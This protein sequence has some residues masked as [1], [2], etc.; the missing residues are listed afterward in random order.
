MLQSETH[1][2]H[3]QQILAANTQCNTMEIGQNSCREFPVLMKLIDLQEM[4][5]MK[6]K[7]ARKEVQSQSKTS[8]TNIFYELDNR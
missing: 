2:I 6:G 7:N 5:I 8:I 3:Q 4:N 1:I